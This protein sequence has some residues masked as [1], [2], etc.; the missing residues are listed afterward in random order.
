MRNMPFQIM[1][2]TFLQYNL[3]NLLHIVG[4]VLV[5]I[6]IAGCDLR[7][8]TVFPCECQVVVDYRM[9]L[10]I[11]IGSQKSQESGFL[12][13]IFLTEDVGNTLTSIVD[14]LSIS[15]RDD[16]IFLPASPSKSLV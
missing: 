15:F 13:L 10:Q 3:G 7:D 14:L 12:D 6:H 16:S 8:D 1:A 5:I 9:G 2:G 11:V 4:G